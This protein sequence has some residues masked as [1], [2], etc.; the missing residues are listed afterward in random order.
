MKKTLT[1]L[2]LLCLAV[3]Q[4]RDQLAENR[5]VSPGAAGYA[6]DPRALDSLADIGSDH[7]EECPA[8]PLKAVPV[9]LHAIQQDARLFQPGQ[10]FFSKRHR[11]EQTDLSSAQFAV[12]SNGLAHGTAAQHSNRFIF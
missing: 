12:R 10:R 5:F 2:F 3:F 6:D 4:M 1:V 9:M 7:I 11:V 8:A